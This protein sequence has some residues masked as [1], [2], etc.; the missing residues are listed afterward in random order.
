[1]SKN[2]C[3]S[4]P[5]HCDSSD[6][7]AAL[8]SVGVHLQVGSD[9]NTLLGTNQHADVLPCDGGLL[10]THHDAT[11]CGHTFDPDFHV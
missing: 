7:Q 1:M 10:S 9:C 5:T 3:H 8:I 4:E 2:Q 11:W 6:H